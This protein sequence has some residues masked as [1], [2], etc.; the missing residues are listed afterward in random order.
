MSFRESRSYGRV[1]LSVSGLAAFAA[2]NLASTMLSSQAFAWGKR[3]HSMVCETAAYILLDDAKHIAKTDKSASKKGDKTKDGTDET[4]S[5]AAV[6]DI[7]FL[8]DHSYDLG[9]YCN[10][11]DLVWKREA[12]YKR[13]WFNHFMD[14]EIFQREL[15]DA[16]VEKPFSLSRLE[17]EK[18]FPNIKETAGRSF[19][20][21]QELMHASDLITAELKKTTLAHDDR[22]KL[23]ASWLVHLGALG[24]YVGDL[25]QPLHVTENYDGQMSNQKGVHAWFEDDA[26]NELFLHGNK[27]LGIEVF[28][29]AQSKWKKLSTKWGQS[30]PLEIAQDLATESNKEI[31][32]LLKIDQKVGRKSLE[33][34]AL[35]FHDMIVDR[36]ATGAVALATLWRRELGWEFD[37]KKFY[38]FVTEPDYIDYPTELNPNPTPL[39]PPPISPVKH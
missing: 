29:R 39:T 35:A 36:M 34:A 4:E 30:S 26:V 9:F 20:R 16:H 27:G 33:K 14:M 12:T 28:K 19:W 3:G 6:A 38:T 32:K 1:G 22:F 15:K 31:P 13:E 24:H 18:A 21:I 10:A 37:S 25:A 11:P 5:K 8:A 23:Q 17:F 2:F 7:G